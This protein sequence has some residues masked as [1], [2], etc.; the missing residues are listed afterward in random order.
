MAQQPVEGRDQEGG[1]LAGAGLGLAGDVVS[2]ERDGQGL[3]LDRRAVL[4][5]RFPDAL[6][7]GFRKVEAFEA[8]AGF[9]SLGHVSP[10]GRIPGKLEFTRESGG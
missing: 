3:G 9:V 2:G 5:A 7:Y 4:E 8:D 1:G 6:K 10:M